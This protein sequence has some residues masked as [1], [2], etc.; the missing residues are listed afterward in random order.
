MKKA[1]RESQNVLKFFS[2]NSLFRL[3]DKLATERNPFAAVLY[4]KL[5][6]SL[7]E[8]YNDLEVREF[9]LQNFI[10][11]IQKYSS[12]PIDILLEPFVKQVMMNDTNINLPD[13][14][15]FKF[16][17]SHPKMKIRMAIL[18]LDLLSKVYLNNITFSHLSF[19]PI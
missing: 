4:K 16:L 8:N 14:L 9:M 7:I 13:M 15:M 2:L 1:T 6:F 18:L 5:T 11:L 3:L 10:F 17:A 19:G 12:I